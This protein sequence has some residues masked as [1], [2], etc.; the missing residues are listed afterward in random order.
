VKVTKNIDY[1]LEIIQFVKKK[2]IDKSIFLHQILNLYVCPHVSAFKGRESELAGDPLIHC[3]IRST[4][5][6]CCSCNLQT[7]TL[8][9]VDLAERTNHLLQRRLTNFNA[10]SFAP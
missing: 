3:A 8:L 5:T 4:V 10:M 9:L 7:K 2:N 1:F 6:V